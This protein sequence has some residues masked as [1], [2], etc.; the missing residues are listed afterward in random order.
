MLWLLQ[1]P[2]LVLGTLWVTVIVGISVGG[3]LLFRK[4]MPAER[5]DSANTVS[6]TMFQLAGTL[7]A[8]LVAFVVVVVWEQ[9]SDAEDASGQEAAAIADLLRDSAALPAQS[10]LAVE[11]AL[12]DYTRT[13]VDSEFPRMHHGEHVAE[14][15]PELIAVWENY[16]Q[17]QPETRNQIA[18]FDHAIVRLNDMTSFRKARVSTGDS[19]VPVELWVLLVGGGGV[20]MA[21]TFLSGTRD[22]LVH[23]L[24]VGLTAALLSFVLYLIFALEH[25]YVGKLSVQPTAYLSVLQ[26]WAD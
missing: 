24:G 1:I 7:Y 21:F 12:I 8:V 15:S 20:V 16:L 11:Q 10:Q 6:T 3:L 17:V 23:S 26:S 2:P 19:S 13:V 14:Q 4:V 5:F 9:F 25:P 22:R 18:F